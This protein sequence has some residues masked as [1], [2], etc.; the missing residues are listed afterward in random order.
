MRSSTSSQ[1]LLSAPGMSSSIL[2]PLSPLSLPALPLDA[3]TALG[4][5]PLHSFRHPEPES[6]ADML[7]IPGKGRCYVYLAKYTY[8]PFNQ[9]PND[10]PEAEV[11]LTAG[12]YVLVWGNMDEVIKYWNCSVQLLNESLFTRTVSTRANF[13]TDVKDSCRP[14]LSNGFKAKTWW[15]FTGPPSWVCK[16]AVMTAA[17]QVYPVTFTVSVQIIQPVVR[18]SSSSSTASSPQ[19]TVNNHTNN[20]YSNSTRFKCNTNPLIKVRIDLL[21]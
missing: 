13:W 19:R 1:H 3:L 17:R 2:P 11:S 14:T 16:L 4:T 7:E 5:V 10:N 20:T 18:V 21:F 12:D 15:N 6:I 8:E 9:S